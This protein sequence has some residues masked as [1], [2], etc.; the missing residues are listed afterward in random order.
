MKNPLALLLP[1]ALL[2]T[3]CDA[4]NEPEKAVKPSVTFP[5]G[6]PSFGLNYQAALDL[7]KKANKPIVLVFSAKWCVPC[8]SMKK[9]VYHSKEVTPLHDKFVWAYLDI[10]EEANAS[11]AQKYNVDIIPHIQFLS[12]QG[13][14]LGSSVGGT[15]ARE[16]AGILGTV[17]SKAY[18]GKTTPTQVPEPGT[19]RPKPKSPATPNLPK[20]S[21]ASDASA[22]DSHTKSGETT[23][24]INEIPPATPVTPPADP[25]S[26]N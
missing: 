13:K 2:A 19:P 7:G 21:P 12:P 16:F 18:P 14:E 11:A 17:L 15:S 10:D 20:A 26:A 22:S 4:K 1:F 5:A 6:S 9:S 23:G 8:Q 25:T 24:S 3:S